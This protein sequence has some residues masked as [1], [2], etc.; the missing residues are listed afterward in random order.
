MRA[1]QRDHDDPNS[2][3]EKARVTRRELLCLAALGALAT[4]TRSV[5]S[6]IYRSSYG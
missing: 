6:A 4:G 1:S 5:P 3:S 2:G